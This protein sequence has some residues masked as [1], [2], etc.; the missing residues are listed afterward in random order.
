[1]TLPLPLME[2]PHFCVFKES[3]DRRGRSAEAVDNWQWCSKRLGGHLCPLTPP[4]QKPLNLIFGGF[5]S[6]LKGHQSQRC[7]Q[8]E[9]ADLVLIYSTKVWRNTSSF[10]VSDFLQQLGCCWKFSDFYG[11]PSWWSSWQDFSV[12]RPLCLYSDDVLNLLSYTYPQF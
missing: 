11:S 6:E 8:A 3:F 7:S 2:S 9:Y 5:F 4:K 1:M 12:A 10:I